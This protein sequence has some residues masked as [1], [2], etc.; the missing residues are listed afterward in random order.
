MRNRCIVATGALV[1][2]VA[3]S[4]VAAEAEDVMNALYNRFAEKTVAIETL[5]VSNKRQTLEQELQEARRSGFIT[6]GNCTRGRIFSTRL[7][8]LKEKNPGTG[9]RASRRIS[10]WR[11]LLRQ[12]STDCGEL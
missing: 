3:G 4:A 5:A 7:S 10:R 12:F 1:A 2:L 6:Q 11:S 8:S 9:R